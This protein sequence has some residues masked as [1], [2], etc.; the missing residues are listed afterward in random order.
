MGDAANFL[1]KELS[2]LFGLKIAKPRKKQDP[3]YGR[4]Y[5]WCKKM[6]ITF[7]RDLSYW[8]FSD[9]RIGTI[10][11]NDGGYDCGTVL[12]IAKKRIKTG[13]PEATL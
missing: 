2:K 4:L 5:R 10:G 13:N 8:D 6:K 9:D 7:S 1:D 12:E 11:L 3:D